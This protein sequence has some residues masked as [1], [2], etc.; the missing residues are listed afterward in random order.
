MA[1]RPT[2]TIPASDT[3]DTPDVQAVT[4]SVVVEG[5][6]GVDIDFPSTISVDNFPVVQPVSGNVTVDNPTPTDVSFL[7]LE[8]TQ[9]LVNQSLD[10]I[11]TN[12]DNR[13]A[14][15]KTPVCIT[16]TASGDTTVYTPAAGN[17][18]RLF[19]VSAKPAPDAT[20]FPLIKISIGAMECYRDWVIQH[21]EVFEGDEDEALIVNLDAVASIPV[22][23]HLQEFTP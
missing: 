21:W 14:G 16:A 12:T 5:D 22:T 7:A 8:A 13:Y 19:W 18:V 11:E 6:V 9:F 17:A 2:Y 4:G 23:V 10:T 20:V 3:R 1:V 15:A